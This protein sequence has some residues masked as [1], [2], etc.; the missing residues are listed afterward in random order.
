MHDNFPWILEGF[1]KT[2]EYLDP[3][4]LKHIREVDAATWAQQKSQSN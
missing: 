4:A 1:Y 3:V 2:G